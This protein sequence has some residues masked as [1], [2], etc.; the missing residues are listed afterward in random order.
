MGPD[1][2]ASVASLEAGSLPGHDGGPYLGRRD[3]RR[4]AFDGPNG[5]GHS[6]DGRSL[7][8]LASGSSPGSEA[9]STA[10]AAFPDSEAGR[11]LHPLGPSAFLGQAL[12]LAGLDDGR[13]APARARTQARH[14]STSPPHRPLRR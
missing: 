8:G 14:D 6:P 3:N 7:P 2:D 4:R 11:A 10:N 13:P 9:A 5:P 1:D 12:A